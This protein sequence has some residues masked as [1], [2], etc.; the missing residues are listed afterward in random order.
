[1]ENWGLVI[2]REEY[3]L[4]NPA[5]DSINNKRAISVAISHELSHQWV[6]CNL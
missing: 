2:F 4:F 6:K 1:M 5:R 3:L